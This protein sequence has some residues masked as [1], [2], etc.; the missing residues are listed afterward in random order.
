MSEP[1][2]P[3]AKR[4]KSS[5]RQVDATVIMSAICQHLELVE[6]NS[7]TGVWSESW[8]SML[9]PKPLAEV[10]RQAATGGVQRVT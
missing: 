5:L 9:R 3:T 6:R 2:G 4:G 8:A 10:L 7:V 1:C